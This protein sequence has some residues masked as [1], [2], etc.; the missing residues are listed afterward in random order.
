MVKITHEW[1]GAGHI[2]TGVMGR[3]DTCEEP[4]GADVPRPAPSGL[5]RRALVQLSTLGLL[6]V[7][8]VVVEFVG[9]V[10]TRAEVEAWV[11]QAGPLAPV[12][13]LVIYAFT[14]LFPVPKNLLSVLAGLLF[15]M[16]WGL[17]LVWVAAMV[18]AVT[19]FA[20]GRLLGRE[21]V[22]QLT[23]ARVA[24]IDQILGRHGV[25]SMIGVR[26]IPVLPFTVINY[27]AGLTGLPL[28][29]YV[30]G[31]AIGIIPGT[32][33]FVALGAYSTDLGS[34]PIITAVSAL[35]VLTVGGVVG[36]RLWR[37]RRLGTAP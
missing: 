3:D 11:N 21:A 10:P 25:V 33:A 26:L 24:S 4:G 37:R 14:T 1:A 2:L 12:Y 6:L 34:W 28:R 7:L 9:G 8:V 30:A 16:W 19:A 36:A 5:S 31:T 13:F 15:G 23:G 35:I 17:A 27:T 32:V 18:G 20:I 29:A 22:E